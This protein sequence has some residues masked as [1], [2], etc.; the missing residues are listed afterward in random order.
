MTKPI[1]RLQLTFP[2]AKV[3]WT[4]NYSSFEEYAKGART[5]KSTMIM[6]DLFTRGAYRPAALISESRLD[7]ST[8]AVFD[9][10]KVPVEPMEDELGF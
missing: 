1:Y 10:W 7:D 4:R 6:Q 3:L 2:G 8:W 5:E 9:C